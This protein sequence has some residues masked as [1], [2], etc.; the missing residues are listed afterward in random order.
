LKAERL[1]EFDCE[2][3]QKSDHPELR[4]SRAL[5]RPLLLAAREFLHAANLDIEIV[6]GGGRGE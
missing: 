5:Q 3:N 4:L 2:R 1:T 6:G